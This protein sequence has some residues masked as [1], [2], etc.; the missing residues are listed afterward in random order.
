MGNPHPYDV[1]I[2]Q[3]GYLLARQEQL[4]RG[5]RAWQVTSQG[6]SI[7]R[8]GTAEQRFG[9]QP[10]TIELPIVWES[11]HLG[12]GDERQRQQDGRYHYAVDVDARFPEMVIP[13][14]YVNI[15]DTGLSTNI[16]SF[17]EFDGALYFLAGRYVKTL[18]ENGT[19][20]ASLDLGSN[21][22][23]Y[24]L[25]VF[26]NCL[27]VGQGFGSG[28]Y[29]YR[30][31]D[32]DGGTWSED[33]DVQ[34]GYLLALR[35]RL[36]A[37]VSSREIAWITGD[38]DPFDAGLWSAAYP[39][40]ES[41]APITGLTGIGEQCYVAKS[42]GLYAVDSDGII[43]ELAPELRAYRSAG[44]GKH[45]AAW[46][47]SIWMPHIRG[48]LEYR[49]LGDSGHLIRSVGPARDSLSENPVRGTITALAGDDR[50]L[51]AAL[52]NNTDTYILAG[53]EAQSGEETLG[54]LIWHP[55]AKLA[56]VKCEALYISGLWDNP[57]LFI[58]AGPNLAYI[59]LPRW[60]DNPLS[61]SNCR[62]ARS[63]RIYYSAHDSHVPATFK[64]YKSLEVEVE[65]ADSD[66]Y[67]DV[68]YRVD[69]AD[70]AFAGRADREGVTTL[71]LDPY[72]VAGKT[73]EVRINFT[74]AD[75]TRSLRLRRVVARG[76]ERPQ[77]I[78]V[79]TAV[80][81]C[82]DRLAL[83]NGA[84]DSRTGAEILRELWALPGLN[85]SVTLVDTIG[86]E[87]QVLVQSPIDERET[88]QQAGQS[89]EVLA[90]VRMSLFST[91]ETASPWTTVRFNIAV[92]DA[93]MDIPLAIPWNVGGTA[94]SAYQTVNYPG[95]APS[96]PKIK[97][98]GPIT[99]FILTN[100]TTGEKLDLTGATIAAGDYYIIDMHRSVKICVD[101]S[102]VD[103]S[104]E[105]SVD[106][107]LATFRLTPGANLFHLLGSNITNATA[108]QL[109]YVVREA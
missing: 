33:G 44:T 80:I 100:E 50:W 109:E 58:G 71:E 103:R 41:T 74:L 29:L 90:T 40:G 94:L 43:G 1:L 14:P 79:I 25:A 101:S 3:R 8:Q 88:A 91:Q 52:Y 57:R 99:N 34:A 54:R 108:V 81:R 31:T 104:G 6:A 61:D 102:G 87:R 63:G 93:E 12:Y 9:N 68:Y 24:N 56:G 15:V 51:Y 4:E 64:L 13:G 70:W 65:G 86:S 75:N 84:H 32:G 47:G 106:S 2:N 89:R 73:L 39:V 37:Q 10:A 26:N 72:G 48:L 18:G 77:L 59:I 21:K 35:D 5:G 107:D 95:T 17:A 60:T 19:I 42:D 28:D 78:D 69:G 92:P 83:N 7:A 23:G 49:S 67:V 45:V 85:Q 76:A 11:A 22:A 27:Y 98:T 105:L 36:Y 20:S 55:L 30:R 96:Y 53:R 82:A 62:F 97:V 46:H 38:D 66:N 16:T